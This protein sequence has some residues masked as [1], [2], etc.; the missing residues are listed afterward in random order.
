M[1][2]AQLPSLVCRRVYSACAFVLVWSRRVVRGHVCLISTMLTSG[3]GAGARDEIALQH[4][5]G[6]PFSDLTALCALR[7]SLGW[8]DLPP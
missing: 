4:L 1:A 8:R 6:V 5:R 2:L 3:G 7:T